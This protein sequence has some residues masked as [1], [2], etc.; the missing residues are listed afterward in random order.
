MSE[1]FAFWTFSDPAVRWVVLGSVCLG[2]S[3]GLLGC[4]AFL[5]KQSLVGDA[6]AHAALP[7]VT[8]MFLATHS[9]DPLM[10]LL[11][12]TISC[13]LGMGAIEYLTRK[14]KIKEDSALAIVLSLFFALGIFHLTY[15]QKLG[16]ASQ[17]GLDRLLFG[18]AAS[19][20][21]HDVVVLGWISVGLLSCI[22]IFF[23]RFKILC[24]DRQYAITLG[25]N[26]YWYDSLLALL[27]VLSVS[28]GLQLVGV[29]LMAAILITPAASARYWSHNLTTILWLA[30][31]FG[32]ISGIAGANISYLAPRMP[33]GPW[34]VVAVTTIFV[35]SLFFAP[36]RGIGARVFKR[37]VMKKKVQEEN[38][39]RTFFKLRE[40]SASPNQYHEPT[41]ILERRNMG[42][43]DLEATIRRLISKGDL[44]KWGNKYRLSIQGFGHAARIT[45]IHRLWELYLTKKIHLALDHVHDDAEEIEHIITPELEQKLLEELDFPLHDPHGKSIPQGI[46]KD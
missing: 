29:V 18:Q 32:A 9:R 27:L 19:L 38:L 35:V 33:T 30:G 7:G 3:A 34:I 42:I 45:R 40:E 44:E 16:I 11:G 39:L 21:R 46:H 28:I 15:I 25:L 22:A 20:V 4:F 14:T 41:K 10:I 17:A 8:T 1:F 26:V 13:F 6:L 5:R 23:H 37:I 2:F 36:E 43:R 12:A 31:I 24:F